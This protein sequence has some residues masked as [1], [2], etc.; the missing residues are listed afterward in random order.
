MAYINVDE[1]YILDNTGLQVDMATDIPFADAGFTDAQ[2]EQARANIAAGGTN[3]NLLDNPWWGSNEVINQRGVSSATLTTTMTYT[4]D[5][6]QMN[7]STTAGSYSLG[8]DG[9]TFTVG[10]RVYARQLFP[11]V[12]RFEG[13]ALTVSMLLS[14]GTI[15][16]GTIAS[17]TAGTEQVFYNGGGTKIY[18]AT[19]NTL[20]FYVSSNVTVRAIK[21]ELGTVSTLANDVPPDYG[22]ELAKCQRYFYRL[23]FVTNYPIGYGYAQTATSFRVAIPIPVSMRAAL[24]SVSYSGSPYI[25]GQGSSIA[26][27]ALSASGIVPTSYVDLAATVSGATQFQSYVLIGS[28]TGYID[29]SADL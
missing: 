18:F 27:T 17:R 25:I 7:Y 19:T 12:T 5:R 11:D 28:D 13:K 29:L 6:W 24:S 9:I 14:D 21:L 1:V 20:N 16:S 2:K 8:T 26:V 23:P 15:L 22:T 10:Y 4:I 3:P